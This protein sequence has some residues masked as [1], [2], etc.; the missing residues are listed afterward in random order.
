MKKPYKVGNGLYCDIVGEYETFK[1]ALEHY[2]KIPP[3]KRGEWRARGL[4]NEDRID[5][6]DSSGLTEEEEA[7]LGVSW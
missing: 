3:P 4:W 2:K 5:I 7:Q 1:E 6:G